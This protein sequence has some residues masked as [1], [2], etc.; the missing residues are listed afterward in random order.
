M[1]AKATET[2]ATI[3]VWDS[4]TFETIATFSTIES[5]LKWNEMHDVPTDTVSING[6]CLL[7]WDELYDFV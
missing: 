4:Q 3:E 5:L 2:K 6:M 1:S 7:G